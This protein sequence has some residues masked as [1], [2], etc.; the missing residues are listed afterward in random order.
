LWEHTATAAAGF[1]VARP[2]GYV[3][4]LRT[5]LLAEAPGRSLLAL[6]R[7]ED[8]ALPA[9]VSAAHAIAAFH[10]LPVTDSMAGAARG[11]R[12]E[13]TRLATIAQT[14]RAAVP[15]VAPVLDPLVA[16]IGAQLAAAPLAPTHFDLK[17]GH[18]LLDGERVTILDLDKVEVADPL[19]DVANLV[20]SLGKVRRPARHGE[21]RSETLARAFTEAYF[22]QVPADW[23]ARFPARHALGLLADAVTTQRG[24]RGRAE[25]ANRAARMVA[26]VH[27]AA[28][29]VSDSRA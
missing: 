14:L 19:L 6:L 3:A 15:E 27:A 21:G 12:D 5:L 23:R 28:D 10:Q 2:I 22:A 4:K 20:T 11:A 13:H 18:L 17:P 25:R 9:V 7:R 8:E 29:I 1:T 26:L 24:L 16:T